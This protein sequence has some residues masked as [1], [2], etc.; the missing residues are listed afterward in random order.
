MESK[1]GYVSYNVTFQHLM[2]Y[3]REH[4]LLGED[5]SDDIEYG[6]GIIYPMPGGLKENVY[7]FCGED[8]FIRQV[9]GEKHVYE[10]LKKYVQ[11]VESAKELPFMVDALNCSQGCL[12]GTAVEPELAESE[13]IYF[14]LDKIRKATRAREK[15]VDKKKREATPE[16]RLELLNQ[17]FAELKI[18]DFVRNYTDKSD[19]CKIAAPTDK[20]LDA[21]FLSMEKVTQ[22]ERMVNCSACGYDNCRAMAIAIH[23]KCNQ[24]GNCIQFEKKE[25]LKDTEKMLEMTKREQEKNEHIAE[26]VAKDFDNLDVAIKEVSEG[27]DVTVQE[28]AEIQNAMSD[29]REFCEG[30]S[31]SFE[32]I[33]ELLVELEENN[34][35]VSISLSVP[36][37]CL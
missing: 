28:S 24:S 36:A 13:D 29:I 35:S 30:M 31:Q 26:V 27:N 8:L 17:K 5:A 32:H 3:M 22:Q 10:Y 25:V 23:N 14:A 18:E 9:E 20:E 15:V 1:L 19:K 7:W 2:Q 11:R 12:Y 34:K 4:H 33:S 37:C 6:L 16:M 21:I